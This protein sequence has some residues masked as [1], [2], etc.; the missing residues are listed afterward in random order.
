MNADLVNDKNEALGKAKKKI[1]WGYIAA[2]VSA[3]ITLLF[4]IIGDMWL[5]VDVVFTVVLAVLLITL[6][7]R[8]AAVVLFLH[9]TVSQIIMRLDNPYTATDGIFLVL[10][11]LSLYFNCILGTFSYHK[12]KKEIKE[13]KQ[14]QA[15]L[16]TD[17]H[18]QKQDM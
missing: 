1:M 14:E 15:R 18:Y 11:F 4:A 13:Q 3:A 10:I 8:I 9:Y 2:F 5:I 16:Q 17:T 7:S 6:K 12:I